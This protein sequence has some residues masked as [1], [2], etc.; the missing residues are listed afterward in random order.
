[1]F[2]SAFRLYIGVYSVLQGCCVILC[3]SQ[4]MYCVLIADRSFGL[5]FKDLCVFDGTAT[6][7]RLW[8]CTNSAWPQTGIMSHALY[9]GV[10]E[11][12]TIDQEHQMSSQPLLSRPKSP[13]HT[14]ILARVS[15]WTRTR[16]L[17]GNSM[18]L[19]FQVPTRSD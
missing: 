9:F 16:A 6:D 12:F 3:L 1:M 8:Y 2:W 17:P 13:H 19:T 10:L 15:S 18:V 14:M 7:L 4:Q 5:V 11:V